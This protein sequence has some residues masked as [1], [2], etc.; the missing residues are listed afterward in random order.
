MPPKSYEWRPGSA[1]GI[2]LMGP[3]ESKWER[4]H[5]RWPGNT[6][7]YRYFDSWAAALEA[8]GIKPVYPAQPEGTLAER[9]EAARSMHAAGE[10]KRAI[11]DQL[12]VTPYT[13]SRYLRAHRCRTCANPVIGK[14]KRCHACSTR[15]ANPMRWSREEV[16]AAVGGDPRRPARLRGGVR[17]AAGKGWPRMA[18][19]RLSLR[20][21]GAPPLRLLHR[22]DHGRRPRAEGK[23]VERGG[24]HRGDAPVRARNRPLAALVGLDRCLRGLAV[25][26]HRLP[27]FRQLAGSSRHR[28]GGVSWG[29]L[30]S[31]RR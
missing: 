12:G 10:S 14:A 30:R 23:T 25:G 20:P 17:Q 29:W 15:Q 1:R 31:P 4:E 26:E 5:P 18:A 8:A 7:V 9:V 27:P 13:V 6:T 21:H 24:D 19:Q 22:R 28:H 11:A 2:G 16:T 3:E